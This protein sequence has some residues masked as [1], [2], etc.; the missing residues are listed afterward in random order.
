MEGTDVEVVLLQKKYIY[1]NFLFFVLS[2]L[3]VT[4]ER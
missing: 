3:Y 4:I 1:N 2:V